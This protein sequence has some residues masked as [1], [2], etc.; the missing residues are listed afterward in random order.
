VPF[1]IC[2]EYYNW[3]S[4]WHCQSSDVRHRV[5]QLFCRIS[6]PAEKP[7]QLGRVLVTYFNF[8]QAE[9]FSSMLDDFLLRIPVS[10]NPDLLSSGLE[11]GS[12]GSDDSKFNLLMIPISC[13]ISRNMPSLLISKLF[14]QLPCACY[15][16]RQKLLSVIRNNSG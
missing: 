6:R 4:Q 12:E 9:H 8:R 5:Y 3:L 2:P 10:I 11:K 14:V 15:S 13:S 7:S 1:R 16:D